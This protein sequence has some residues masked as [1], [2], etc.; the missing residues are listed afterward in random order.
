MRRGIH[1]IIVLAL[2]FSLVFVPSLYPQVTKEPQTGLDKLDGTIQAINKE[3]S[4]ITIIQ[5]GKTAAWQI[6]YNKDT[7]FSYR[8]TAATIDELKDGRRVIVLG[9]FEKGSNKMTATRID[10]R[11]GK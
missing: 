1:S 2:V 4:T 5:T 3:K 11:E 9:K 8:N 6:V 7:I 10:V